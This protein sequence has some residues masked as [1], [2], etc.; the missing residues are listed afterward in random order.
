MCLHTV[1]HSV[2]LEKPLSTVDSSLRMW[3]GTKPRRKTVW[4]GMGDL[5]LISS[6]WR[7][8][9]SAPSKRDCIC[10]PQ[11]TRSNESLGGQSVPP[12]ISHFRHPRE[13]QLPPCAP[14][15]HCPSRSE[16]RRRGPASPGR[17]RRMSRRVP[18]QAVDSRSLQIGVHTMTKNGPSQPNR[19]MLCFCAY[20]RK[21]LLDTRS[22]TTITF[23]WIH[24]ENLSNPTSC[25]E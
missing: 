25:R 11:S 24:R 7:S 5:A 21:P 1:I 16:E 17:F 19:G 22:D 20:L 9:W 18:G 6:L 13:M 2:L 10:I 14:L 15:C 12:P 4:T 8:T 3:F 23:L